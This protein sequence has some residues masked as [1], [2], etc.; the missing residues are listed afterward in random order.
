MANETV[1]EGPNRNARETVLE[2]R[3]LDNG[4]THASRIALPDDISEKYEYVRDLPS[5]AESDA[6]LLKDRQSGKE[7]FFKYYRPGLSPDPM[8][9]LLLKSA[10]PRY[11]A[12]LIDYHDSDEGCWEI[13][14]YYRFGSLES[15][16]AAM[17]G[18]LSDAQIETA[19]KELAGDLK[20]L[21]G[22]GSGIAHRDLK[23]SNILVKSDS[24]ITLV[25]ADFGLAK[26]NQNIT[27]LTTTVKGTWHYA[28]PE[29]QSKQSSAKSD[30][31]SMG[32]I[33]YE[34]STGRCLF[35]DADG[36]P[37]TDD[38]ARAR[39]MSGYYSADLVEN[40]RI[41]ML[42]TGLLCW[43]KNE[44]WGAEEVERWLAGESPAISNAK[45]GSQKLR[46][47]SQKSRISYR[48]TFSPELA[49]NYPDLAR[50]IRDNWNP[51]A[52]MLAGRPDEKLM[53]FIEAVG[54]DGEYAATAQDILRIIPGSDLP[55]YKLV[56]LQVLLD[57]STTP[58]FR[59]INLDSVSIA[60]AIKGARG[61]DD[62]SAEW[63]DAV[64]ETKA[65]G[66]LSEVANSSELA[67]AD[68]DLARWT[69]QLDE[70]LSLLPSENKEVGK[71]A[72]DTANPILVECALSLAATGESETVDSINRLSAELSTANYV[73]EEEAIAPIRELLESLQSEDIGFAIVFNAYLMQVRDA[74]AERAIEVYEQAK[75]DIE[76]RRYE[77][78]IEK[79]ETIPSYMDADDMR[80]CTRELLSRAQRDYAEAMQEA[81]ASHFERALELFAGLGGYEDASEMAE[82]AKKAADFM[83]GLTAPERTYEEEIEKHTKEIEQR[84]REESELGAE[85]SDA[86]DRFNEADALVRD[87]E[88]A[89]DV[90]CMNAA[91]DIKGQI[92]ALEAE[93][94]GASALAQSRESQ[95]QIALAAR[96]NADKKRS[97]K[98]MELTSAIEDLNAKNG[99][100]KSLEAKI[101]LLASKVK[102]EAKRKSEADKILREKDAALQAALAR[103]EPLAAMEGK[104]IKPRG[105]KNNLFEA[106]EAV[107]KAQRERDDALT[108]SKRVEPSLAS[109]RKSLSTAESDRGALSTRIAGLERNIASL[110]ADVGSLEKT[111]AEKVS[112]LEKALASLDEA[113]SSLRGLEEKLAELNAEAA[114]R[115]DQAREANSEELE[116]LVK[117]RE[118]LE[119]RVKQLYKKKKDA[120]T[121]A[122]KLKED[123]DVLLSYLEK[124]RK[125]RVKKKIGPRAL[126]SCCTVFSEI[127]ET[128]YRRYLRISKA[129]L[130]G[131]KI[132]FGTYCSKQL[133]WDVLRTS[134]G[135]ALLIGPVIAR[136]ALDDS[137]IAKSWEECSLFR[138]L[139][140]TFFKEAFG[141]FE[142]EAIGFACD[143]HGFKVSIPDSSA[144]SDISFHHISGY[145]TWWSAELVH[146]A[147]TW[148]YRQYKKQYIKD[149][150]KKDDC[151]EIIDRV[152]SKLERGNS[153]FAIN[154]RMR[155]TQS[156]SGS[157]DDVI[158]G[159]IIEDNAPYL[160]LLKLDES[161]NG[162]WD[163]GLSNFERTL[164]SLR[165]EALAS[166]TEDPYE[167]LA[168]MGSGRALENGGKA[169]T[170]EADVRPIVWIPYYFG[171][172]GDED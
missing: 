169:L 14:E 151:K 136:K 144:A 4:K 67:R 69:R 147:E 78:A 51:F 88:Y 61:G 159:D 71:A 60:T 110:K 2:A 98:R 171:A 55:E 29:V 134:N 122:A 135:R 166:Y 58:V 157:I 49:R 44:R 145:E 149:H 111:L 85:L 59:G 170:E 106:K 63:I 19:A 91:A 24:P 137:G 37:V 172:R 126:L 57:P 150:M 27:H 83:G 30:W 20:Y 95:Y 28:A 6:I 112:Q 155:M 3:G 97:K 75:A 45:P 156:L 109:A 16:A 74:E 153:R 113:N 12:R 72:K 13:Q 154:F 48:A 39:C 132:R 146:G 5:G 84:T 158:F 163:S 9:M 68:Y 32:A 64:V 93:I 116:R 31:F 148:E 90:L 123:R 21:H 131:D 40:P 102:D 87:A 118:P 82:A 34:Y 26:A 129:V 139:N 162:L 124:A 25:L 108:A 43:D 141:T 105:F 96:D 23:P 92:R 130:K 47:T 1:F 119:R 127:T 140:E 10:D 38:E 101:V 138:W 165:G 120:S 161:G 56:Q 164:E 50:I 94:S 70:A 142:R 121:A 103:F 125:K 77:S 18:V 115:Q 33:L 143:E 35:S 17:G 66:A 15:W 160:W 100:L 46:S 36:N 41:R 42:V 152:K 7:V 133:E 104:L 53:R 52:D 76:S 11:V 22:L 167:R 8:A 99:D 65:F 114:E 81:E 79:L 128:G 62:A 89:L 168:L 107:G 86:Q 117:A 54:Q 73:R 80:Q